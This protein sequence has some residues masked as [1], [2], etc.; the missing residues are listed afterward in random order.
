MNENSRY[1]YIIITAV[2]LMAVGLYVSYRWK[3]S[4]GVRAQESSLTL[5]D[6]RGSTSAFDSV[7]SSATDT[8]PSDSVIA[9]AKQT[10]M[11]Y[12][13]VRDIADTEGFRWQTALKDY[14][15]REPAQA[16]LTNLE[17]DG[18]VLRD[19]LRQ[20]LETDST[21]Q[22]NLKGRTN[23]QDSLLLFYDERLASWQQRL[24][25]QIELLPTALQAFEAQQISDKEYKRIL[26]QV[27]ALEKKQ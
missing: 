13:E 21:W 14:R 27:A 20:A 2:V 11:I 10:K 24:S 26:K 18:V 16:L 22:T 7:Q 25:E 23:A 19:S 4:K 15:F 1:I 9:R 12:T 6:L 17:Q 8:L 5:F 3:M